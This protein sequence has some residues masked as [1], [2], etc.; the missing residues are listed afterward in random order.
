MA[1]A[2]VASLRRKR[3][4]DLDESAAGVGATRA[5]AVV[6]AVHRPKPSGKKVKRLGSADTTDDSQGHFTATPG[7]VIDA[8]CECWRFLAVPVVLFYRLRAPCPL[9]PQ[10]VVAN[11]SMVVQSSSDTGENAGIGLPWCRHGLRRQ[12]RIS[13]LLWWATPSAPVCRLFSLRWHSV[14]RFARI[15]ARELVLRGCSAGFVGIRRLTCSSLFAVV[16]PRRPTLAVFRPFP[17][18]CVCR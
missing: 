15:C 11:G 17:C 9:L 3:E 1:A 7:D 8:R 6:P 2:A 5:A 13:E 18:S 10:V 4:R 14:Y 12:L 16:L